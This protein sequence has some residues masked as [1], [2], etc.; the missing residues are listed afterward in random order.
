MGK[1]VFFGVTN[2][3]GSLFVSDAVARRRQSPD[4]FLARAGGVDVDPLA[5][6]RVVG[7]IVV[8][9]VCSELDFTAAL[10]GDAVNVKL[11]GAFTLGYEGEGLA[12]RRPA[13][14]IAG[15]LEGHLANV[16]A[17]GTGDIDF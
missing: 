10:C 5:I 7:A 6:W 8:L 15:S 14:K 1:P 9:R 12:V 17:I 11:T 16:G 2:N 3:H 13:M 4:S